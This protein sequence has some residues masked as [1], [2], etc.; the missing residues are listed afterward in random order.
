MFY[1]KFAVTESPQHTDAW[2]S[3]IACRHD[4]NITVAYINC[5]LFVN[6]QCF[7]SFNHSV[8]SR[9]LTYALTLTYRHLY[10]AVKEMTAQFLRSSIKL[11]THHSHLPAVTFQSFKH[12]HD[13]RIRLRCVQAMLQIM[14]AEHAVS[15]IKARIIHTSGNSAFHKFFHTVAHKAP[16]FISC[17]F[18]HSTIFQGIITACSQIIKRIQQ[19]SV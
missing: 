11:V 8:W 7:Q 13:S 12:L 14:T 18:G 2:H 1:Q 15:L 4:I 10:I 6:T 16:H 17:T 3:T 5:A 9:F 19:R